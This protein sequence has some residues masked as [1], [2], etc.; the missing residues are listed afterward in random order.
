MNT[1]TGNY[2][3]V[4]RRARQR[5]VRSAA[6]VEPGGSSVVVSRPGQVVVLDTTP[7]PVKV[8]DDV[9]SEPISVDLTLALDAFTHSLAPSA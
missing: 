6:A 7:L 8:L 4:D 3:V 9:C 5:Y 2:A 1:D